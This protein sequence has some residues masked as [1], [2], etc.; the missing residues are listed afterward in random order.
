MY[1]AL[2]L[3]AK[4][5]LPC[6]EWLDLVIFRIFRW[7]MS[8]TNKTVQSVLCW[9]CM[10]NGHSSVVWYNPNGMEPDMHCQRCGE[11]LG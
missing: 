10:W 11:D 5:A 6:L 4:V 1:L 2:R 8:G 9:L 7:D 3:F